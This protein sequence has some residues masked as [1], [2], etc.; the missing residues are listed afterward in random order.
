MR[1]DIWCGSMVC[2]LCDQS[3][4]DLVLALPT[5]SLSSTFPFPHYLLLDTNVILDQIDILEEEV[6][7]NII[8]LTT[9]LD[10]VK[11]KSSSIFKRFKDIIG[12]SNRHIYTFVNE[13]HKLVYLFNKISQN[14]HILSFLGILILNGNLVNQQMIEMIGL[15]GRQLFGTITI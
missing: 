14:S 6:L 12:N 10:E 1:D 3:P 9:V 15:F 7:K 13:H 11:H 8:I 5:K 4:K 2:G